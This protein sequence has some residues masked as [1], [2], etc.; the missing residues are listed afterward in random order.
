MWFRP[1]RGKDI[2]PSFNRKGRKLDISLENV[3]WRSSTTRSRPS[4]PLVGSYE[5]CSLAGLVTMTRDAAWAML[6]TYRF[7][8][9]CHFSDGLHFGIQVLQVKFWETKPN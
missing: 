9:V 6:T 7:Y 3:R 2:S 8:Q 1:I 5:D 4:S